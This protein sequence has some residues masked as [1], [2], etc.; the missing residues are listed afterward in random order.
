M[1]SIDCGVVNDKKWSQLLE[2]EYSPLSEEKF[3]LY[4]KNVDKLSESMGTRLIRHLESAG[5]CERNRVIF[6][7]VTR[8][9]VDAHSFCTSLK[10]SLSCL[11]IKLFPLRQR[12]EDLSSLCSLYLN[13]INAKTGKGVIGLTP[14][15][16]ALIREYPWEQNLTQLQ[17]VLTQLV[18]LSDSPYISA[19]DIS[20]ILSMER[21]GHETP[22]HGLNLNQPL[23]GI[24]RDI[25]HAVLQEEGMSRSKT[26]RRLQISRSTLWRMLK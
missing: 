10:N 6:S 22:R 4:I 12:P 9:D 26:A 20:D 2:N 8:R 11:V 21:E 18:I 25:A 1:V 24:N 17:R 14:E 15:A 7:C 19:G 23:E 13:E 3:T 16:M 5:V